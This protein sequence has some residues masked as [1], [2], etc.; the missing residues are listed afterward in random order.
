MN[1]EAHC[2]RIVAMID[3]AEAELRDVDARLFAPDEDT[4]G[5]KQRRE[6]LRTAIRKAYKAI[7][8]YG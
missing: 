8:Q 4:E 5:L 1:R 7:K 6:V 3:Q 2:L